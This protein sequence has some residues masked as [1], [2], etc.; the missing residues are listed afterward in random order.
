ML[1]IKRYPNRKFYDTEEKRYI[2][3]D[4]ISERIRAGREIQVI[5]Q[6]SG[7]EIT[8]VVLTQIIFEQE[9]KQSG[10]VPRSVLTGLVQAGG[11][12][13]GRMR[14]ALS[15]PLE[16]LKQI[17]EEIESRID[18][19]TKQGELAED[20]A[21]RWRDKLLSGDEGGAQNPVMDEDQFQRLLDERGVPTRSELENLTE[22]IDILM[23]K[24][25]G[26]DEHSESEK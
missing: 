16:L 17:D 24:L 2:T 18:Q 3:L 5:D 22:Q 10:F 15:N 14:S 23:N 25:D 9:K 4:D 19:L 8:S 26:S 20:E 1:T 12:T 21:R 11:Y 7:E 13:M 6:G